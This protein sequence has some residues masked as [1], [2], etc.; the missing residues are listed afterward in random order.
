MFDDDFEQLNTLA[1]ATAGQALTNT[2]MRV[3]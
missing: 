2:S 3:P 1:P